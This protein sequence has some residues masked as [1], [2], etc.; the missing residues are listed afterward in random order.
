[1]L[2][3]TLPLSIGVT[4]PSLSFFMCQMELIMPA[5]LTQE[6]VES[7]STFKL[8]IAVPK[9]GAIIIFTLENCRR[10]SRLS[11]PMVTAA[12]RG[13]MEMSSQRT[14][15]SLYHANSTVWRG[16]QLPVGE[17]GKEAQGKMS[18]GLGLTCYL[19]SLHSSF[20]LNIS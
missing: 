5:L 8:E 1:M 19:P 9:K 20:L 3:L 18:P 14:I 10:I 15:H 13:P 16:L 2:V 12:T 6:E 11:S 7:G 4:Y 17:F